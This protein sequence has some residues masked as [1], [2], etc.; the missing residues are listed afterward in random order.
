MRFVRAR[1]ESRMV[2]WVSMCCCATGVAAARQASRRRA[3]PVHHPVHRGSAESPVPSRLLHVRLERRDH[4]CHSEHHGSGR[5]HRN[6]GV[7]FEADLPLR[8]LP[9]CRLRLAGGRAWKTSTCDAVDKGRRARAAIFYGTVWAMCTRSGFRMMCTCCRTRIATRPNWE[10]PW[11]SGYVGIWPPWTTPR[12][13]PIVPETRGVGL[14][15]YRDC[16]L[17][18]NSDFRST[19]QCQLK[20]AIREV[21]V[22][23]LRALLRLG[24]RAD[25]RSPR[26]RVL[27]THG[28]TRKRPGSRAW[29]RHGTRDHSRRAHGRARRRPGSIVGDAVARTQ[30][31]D[32]GTPRQARLLDSR[33]HP[34][35]AISKINACRCL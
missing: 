34:V 14:G 29:L 6:G 22:G 35:P 23:R 10:S 24:K 12:K 18:L 32:A 4:I 5:R 8:V 33:R 2:F 3:R 17:R 31:I 16:R 19:R 25:A 9:N 7:V 20:Y 26:R 15:A 13:R 27:A 21:G 30:A 11:D 28:G 1:F